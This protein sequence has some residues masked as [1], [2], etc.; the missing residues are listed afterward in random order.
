MP[1]SE[2]TDNML[3]DSCDD[4]KRVG[5]EE[6]DPERVDVKEVGPERVDVEKV[7]S[8]MVDVEE[9]G[10]ENSAKAKVVYWIPKVLIH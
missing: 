6:V 2:L 3:G 8:E 5:V 7:G 10:A 9:V 4:T 1:T